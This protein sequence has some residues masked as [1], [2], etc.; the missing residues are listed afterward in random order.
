MIPISFVKT[1]KSS[2]SCSDIPSRTP[3]DSELSCLLGLLWA[4]A[5]SQLFFVFDDLDS[6][7]EDRPGI[8]LTASQLGSVCCF[9][10][11]EMGLVCLGRE[12]HSGTEPS[13]FHPIKGTRHQS[14]VPLWTLTLGTWQ[15]WCL[16]G[17]SR[18]FF[19][20]LPRPPPIRSSRKGVTVQPWI[21][22]LGG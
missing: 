7:E 17:V 14:D 13:S 21:L 19:C 2:F 9:P 20:P 3:H 11:D 6:S 22:M 16:P 15:R 4:G 18:Y 10:H 5:V 8:L 12:L 1:G